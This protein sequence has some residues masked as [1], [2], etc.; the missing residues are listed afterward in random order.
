MSV[1]FHRSARRR[2]TKETGNRSFRE[3]LSDWQWVEH[4]E[5]NAAAQIEE[6]ATQL[7]EDWE[8]QLP[9]N[10]ANQFMQLIE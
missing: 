3:L 1:D 8:S 7:A 4:V 6:T 5:L 2:H 9:G 10:W